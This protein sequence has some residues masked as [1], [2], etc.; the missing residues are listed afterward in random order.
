LSL[1]F[2]KMV[3]EAAVKAAI[4]DS[5]SEN[6]ALLVKLSSTSSAPA[7]LAGYTT[8]VTHLKDELTSHNAILDKLKED[9]ETRFKRHKKFRD[10]TTRRFIYRAT[11]ML[12]KFD[13]KAMTEEREYFAVLGTQSKAETRRIELQRDYDEAVKAQEPLETAAKEHE[14]THGKID[15]LYEKLFSGPTPGFPVEDEREHRFYAA[16]GKNE[17]TKET[18]RAARRAM[19]ILAVSQAHVKRAQISLR[20]ADQQAVDSVFFLDDA[21]LSLRRGNEYITYAI[22]STGRI[23]G[24]LKPPFLEMV[25]VKLEVDRNLNAAKINVD[26]AYSR[27]KIISTVASAQ[28]NLSGAEEAL[29]KLV[30]LTNEKEHMGLEEIRGTA[31]QLEDTRQEL[32]QTRQGIFE[33]VAG[34]GE[35]APAYNECCDRTEGFYE[36][37]EGP[38]DEEPEGEGEVSPGELTAN[39]TA[40]PENENADA[41]S[42]LSVEAA[43]EPKRG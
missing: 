36:I 13:A 26:E 21:L 24:E 41:T 6:S 38:S 37:P 27:E 9:V 1:S 19:K 5:A 30:A 16:R 39:G 31:R 23:E 7:L 29:E 22:N 18:I 40:L 8:H 28:N 25:A 17:T 32:Q 2:V 20:N 12:A 15:E 3:N 34:F 10:S 43:F 14:E 4:L 11:N 33:K 42:Q 35:A